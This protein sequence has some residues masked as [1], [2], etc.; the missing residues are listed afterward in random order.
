MEYCP[1]EIE[2]KWQGYWDTNN[3]FEP[4]SEDSKKEKKKSEEVE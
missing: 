3:S 4:E 1:Q 2:Q